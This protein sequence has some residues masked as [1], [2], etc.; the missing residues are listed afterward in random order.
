MI[1]MILCYFPL[2]LGLQI[3]TKSMF[4]NKIV[5]FIVDFH[6]D[7]HNYTNSFMNNNINYKIITI[8]NFCERKKELKDVK[9][10][11]NLK[12]FLLV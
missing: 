8:Y 7:K 4:Y 3:V 5:N 12:P 1:I 10:F 2:K 11:F 9:R 6:S